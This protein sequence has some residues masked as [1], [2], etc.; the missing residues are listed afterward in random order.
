MKN[1]LI[2]GLVILAVLIVGGIFLFV[3]KETMTTQPPVEQETL[4]PEPIIEQ[5]KEPVPAPELPVVKEFS[6]F[7]DEKSVNPKTINV[8]KGDI[9]KIIFNFNPNN[10]YYGGLDIKDSEKK[11]INVQYRKGEN[12]VKT[13]EFIAEKSFTYTGYWP[14]TNKA[15][16]SGN[17][18]VS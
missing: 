6:I 11:Y 3:Q 10:I 4:Q 5:P 14:N 17:F 7:I 9:I 12:P 16:A 8:N 15:K 18:I 13:T 2:I 1:K